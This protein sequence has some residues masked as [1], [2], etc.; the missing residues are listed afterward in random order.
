MVRHFKS[1]GPISQIVSP[2]RDY[3]HLMCQLVLKKQREEKEDIYERLYK[4]HKEFRNKYNCNFNPYDSNERDFN[5]S[6]NNFE[7]D[8]LLWF[9]NYSFDMDPMKKREIYDRYGI[10]KVLSKLSI[11]A[12]LN[13][14]ENY[15]NMLYCE[16][17][18]FTEEI[19]FEYIIK[20]IVYDMI[21]KK[22]Q[23]P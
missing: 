21:C 19:V 1:I 9:A 10:S 23:P 4:D 2:D 11:I 17:E 7:I 14:Y 12:K 15:D 5:I 8:E 22:N 18:R 16:G 13:N 20:D 3:M 6:K